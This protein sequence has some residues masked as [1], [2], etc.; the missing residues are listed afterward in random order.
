MALFSSWSDADLE[1]VA[2]S[3]RVQ[4]QAF[5]AEAVVLARL[6][7][8]AS[9]R[10]EGWSGRAPWAGLVLEVAGTVQVSQRSAESRIA[11]A[12]HLVEMLPRTLAALQSGA[13]FVPH[14]RT[15][16]RETSVCSADVCAEVERQVLATASACTP[17][18]LGKL[19]QRAVLSADPVAA[20][21]AHEEAKKDRATWVKPAPDGM[22]MQGSYLTAVQGKR[23]EGDLTALLGRTVKT[24]GDSRTEQQR[25]ADLLADLPALALEL[26]DRGSGLL[27]PLGIPS[28]IDAYGLD[29]AV[30]VGNRAT[31]RR[32]R[33]RTTVVA[34]VPVDTALALS[35]APVWLDGYGW[36]TAGQGLALLPEAELRKACIDPRSGRLLSLGEPFVPGVDDPPA[37]AGAGVGVFGGDPQALVQAFH[38]AQDAAARAKAALQDALE[39]QGLDWRTAATTADQLTGPVRPDDVPERQHD[40]RRDHRRTA[41]PAPAVGDISDAVHQALLRMVTE[42]TVL[43]PDDPA[44][45][46]E[47]Q[48]DPSEPL[49]EFVDVRDAGCDGIGCSTPATVNDLDHEDPWPTGPTTAR[50]L[51][52]RSRRCHGA[53]HH[54]WQVEVDRDGWST[55]TSPGGRTYRRPPRHVPPPPVPPPGRRPAN[56]VR[57]L[58]VRDDAADDVDHDS[59]TAR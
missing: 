3:Q 47:P 54:G 30:P 23:F 29:A 11:D 17:A 35:D 52:N 43:Q 10:K 22:V 8:Q 56:V 13:L 26:L 15:I 25:R 4:A 1:Q 7:R 18:E 27:P 32:R 50:A 6:F 21:Q 20:E 38:A 14:A 28:V 19:V 31:R 24:D 48:H 33:R 2:Q 41:R 59:E 44:L 16:I 36:I 53:K 51:R 49:R 12:A 42:A 57:R 40:H 37:P 5:A 9:D 58:R 46:T 55:W 34:Q 45:R 39:A